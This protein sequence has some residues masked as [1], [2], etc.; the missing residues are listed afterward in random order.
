MIHRG[1]ADLQGRGEKQLKVLGMERN[2][3]VVLEPDAAE[4]GFSAFV[5]ALPEI[6]TQGE[7]VETALANA[8]DAIQVALTY[9]IQNGLEIPES[10]S[11]EVHHVHVTVPPAA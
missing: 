8:A 2:F 11:A 9:R 5:P 7:S 6:A 1:K 3:A 10:D 4:G